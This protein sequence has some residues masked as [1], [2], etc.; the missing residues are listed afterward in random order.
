MVEIHRQNGRIIVGIWLNTSNENNTRVN[1]SLFTLQGANINQFYDYT[2][3]SD[4]W[5][6][7]ERKCK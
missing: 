4:L 3:N 6:L 2:I 7:F 1:H 5:D